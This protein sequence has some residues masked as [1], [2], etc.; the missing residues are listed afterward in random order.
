MNRFL[1]P[2][3]ILVGLAMTGYAIYFKILAIHSPRSTWEN[4][5]TNT[6][7]RSDGELL[8]EFNRIMDYVESGWN[9]VIVAGVAVIIVASLIKTRPK[10]GSPKP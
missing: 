2:V 5:L 1:K 3:L 4:N 8:T 10:D 7:R 6:A 9:V